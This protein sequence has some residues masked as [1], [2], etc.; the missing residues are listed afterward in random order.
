LLLT[1]V[2][3]FGLQGQQIMRQ[4][5]VIVLLAVPIVIGVCFNAGLA[6]WLNRKLRVEWCVRGLQHRLVPAIFSSWLWQRQSLCSAFNRV[7][8]FQPSWVWWWKCRSC[9]RSCTSFG[10]CVHG[11]KGTRKDDTS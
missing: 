4:P 6:Y 10:A 9:C 8:R 5:V 7:P 3:L 1:L 11:M 2:L